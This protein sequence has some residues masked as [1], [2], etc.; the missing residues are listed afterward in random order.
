LGSLISKDPPAYLAIVNVNIAHLY[1]YLFNAYL[2][3][4]PNW[5]LLPGVLFLLAIFAVWRRRRERAVL[6]VAI[7]IAIPMVTTIARGTKSCIASR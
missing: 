5:P 4:F 1:R 3:P 2:T 7:A 6:A